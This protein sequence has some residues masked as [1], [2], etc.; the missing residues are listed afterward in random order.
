MNHSV[1]PPGLLLRAFELWFCGEELLDLFS[2]ERWI[3]HLRVVARI[4]NLDAS[5]VSKFSFQELGV[6]FDHR[7]VVTLVLVEIED[8][9]A[10]LWD[11]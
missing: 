6:R 2:D 11:D 3:I 1:R 10:T 4:R 7:D 9:I 5:T 8:R